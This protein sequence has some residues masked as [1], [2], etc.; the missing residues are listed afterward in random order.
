[1]GNTGPQA[2]KNGISPRQQSSRERA[3]DKPT[4]RLCVAAF[5]II[6]S[7]NPS[8]N[9]IP[10]YAIITGKGYKNHRLRH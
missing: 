1:M 2:S 8:S 7:F 4:A 6:A 9:L 5:L 10:S 3:M